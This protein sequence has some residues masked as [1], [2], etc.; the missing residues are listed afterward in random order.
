M[1]SPRTALSLAAVPLCLA[2]T[3]LAAQEAAQPVTL[4]FKHKTGQAQK[5]A[6]EVKTEATITTGGGGGLGPIPV[7][8]N[9]LYSYSEKVVGTKQ[10]TATLS[11]LLELPSVSANVVGQEYV[12]KKK[13]GKTVVTTNGEPADTSGLSGPAAG[14]ET[15]MKTRKGV[16]RRSPI[17]ELSAVSGDGAELAQMLSSG[18]V[19]PTLRLPDHPVNPG[20]SW[21]FETKFRPAIPG[22]VPS[23]SGPQEMDLKLTYTFKALD[24]KGGKQF[25]LI[26][27]AG[28]AEGTGPQGTAAVSQKG[29][30]RFD[31]ARG[32]VVSGKMSTTLNMAG[33]DAPPAANNAAAGVGGMRIDAVFDV[34]LR[35]VPVTAAPAKAK[36]KR[37]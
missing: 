21:E 24:K 36:G 23:L 19:G 33:S 31:I 15:M 14:L 7:T 22:P 17:G 12:V 6:S 5:F 32:A 8:L 27:T 37:R 13:G 3:H 34:V 25:A 2:A 4:A 26:E 29:T 30:T 20:D 11:S 35:E 18:I 10:G 1:R 9:M 28:N 16:I